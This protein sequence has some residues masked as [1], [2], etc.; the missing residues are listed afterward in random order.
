MS[1]QP[2]HKLKRKAKRFA[3][4]KLNQIK[5]CNKSPMGQQTA[6]KRW[7]DIRKQADALGISY[8]HLQCKNGTGGNMTFEERDKGY[9]KIQ[10]AIDA[11]RKE[12]GFEAFWSEAQTDSKNKTEQRK[13]EIKQQEL[14]TPPKEEKPE[15]ILNADPHKELASRELAR[16]S[17]LHYIERMHPNYEAGWV[18]EDICR[19][20]ERFVREVEERKSP[21]LMLFL[22]PR[23]GKSLIAS[24]YFPAWVL[25]KH[26]EW[27]FIMS[28][29]AADL[30]IGFSRLVRGQVQDPAY[31][32]LFPQ[33]EMS[34]DSTSAEFWRTTKRGGLRAA[35][36]GGGI[37]GMGAH[38]VI[39]STEVYTKH[40]I[41]PISK[42]KIGDEIYAYDHQ[43]ESE[44]WARVQALACS[45]TTKPLVERGGIVTT[46]EHRFFVPGRGYV[47]SQYAQGL[48]LLRWQEVSARSN[49]RGLYSSHYAKACAIG[50]QLLWSN[51]RA[52]T[53]GIREIQTPSW[54]GCE[55]VLQAGMLRRLQETL[56]RGLQQGQR[57]LQ[58]LW[59]AVGWQRQEGILFHTV[60]PGISQRQTSYR[61]IQQQLLIKEESGVSPRRLEMSDLW[62]KIVTIARASYRPQRQQ[63]QQY[64]FN[65]TLPDLSQVVSHDPGA[66]AE[67]FEG[68]LRGE[69]KTVVDIQTTTS[70]FFAGG[71]LVHNC[72][73]PNTTVFTRFGFK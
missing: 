48:P 39:P 42:V 25:G 62:Q 7:R 3:D 73:S 8:K 19:R 66:Y 18:H 37:T 30:P 60:L 55:G 72:V 29:Y 36:V 51:F 43:T 13:R 38:C 41:I 5:P 6:Y 46:P 69:G 20:L 63:Q 58:T 27:E 4:D 67:C 31:N 47:E 44:T 17:L 34:K 23:S 56:S 22:P 40:G 61:G 32:V 45:R 11:K 68:E 26:P 9:W 59:S 52:A 57:L 65:Y 24:T 70:N 35:G 53:V 49:V 15:P 64:K 54:R 16:R 33:T 2:E 10:R 21:R 14:S 28:S 12:L 1:N 50:L 71:V